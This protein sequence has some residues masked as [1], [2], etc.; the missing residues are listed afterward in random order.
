MANNNM[1]E[2]RKSHNLTQ[3]QMARMLDIT[4]SHYEKIE[5]GQR[6]PSGKLLK[7]IKSLFPKFSVDKIFLS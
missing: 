3:E 4:L 2:F 1:K 7:K 6:F 5:Y